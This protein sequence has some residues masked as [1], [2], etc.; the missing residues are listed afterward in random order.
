VAF[1]GSVETGQVVMRAAADRL[2]PVTLEL[3]GKSPNIV[4]ADADLDAAAKSSW[5]A[6]NMNAGQTC[7]AGSRLL[8]HS[9][10]REE[11]VERLVRLN[12]EA[13][14]GPGIDDPDVAAITTK[15]QF[16][17]VKEYLEIGRQDGADVVSGGS[18][19]SDPELSNGFFIEPTIFDNV[20]NSMRIA[21]EEI[22]GPVLSVIAFDTDEE[23]IRIA[24]D[25][26]YGLVAGIWTRDLSRAH[27]VATML[28][29]GQVYVNEWYAG[30]VE[31]PFG[32]AKSSGIGREK[33]VEA[34]SHYTETK[35]VTVRL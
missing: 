7:S 34:V 4:F 3:G 9:S 5:T 24:N 12:G 6:I 15:E 13:S 27:R 22:F 11:L 14:L 23:A 32:G 30:G 8:A 21:Q 17:R 20:N 10:V 26:T 18:A 2:I 35:T 28:E 31:T 33:G 16:E 29:A 25:T 19:A 1:T